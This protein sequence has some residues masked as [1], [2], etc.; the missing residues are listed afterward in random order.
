MSA[1]RDCASPQRSFLLQG[2]PRN[3]R[4][5]LGA[6]TVSLLFSILFRTACTST[7]HRLALD[8]LRHLRGPEAERWAD[9]FLYYHAEFLRGSKA[10]DD[11]FRDFK[12]HVLHVDEN[13]WG[14]ARQEARRWYGRTVD[15]L[16]RREWAEAA[17]AAGVLSHYFSDP[18]MPLHT[19][20]CEE[21]TKV[22]RA[23]EWSISKS[24]GRLQQIIELDLGGY[25]QLEAPPREDWLE[26]LIATGAELAHRHYDAVL[27]HYDLPRGVRDPLTGMDEECCSRIA[28][29]LGH[30]VVGFARVLEKALAE[31]EV[32]PPMVETTLPGFLAILAAPLKLAFQ[33]LYDLGERMTIEAVFD[34]VQRTGKVVK[35]LTPDDREIR[36][37]H[38]EEVLKRPLHQLDQ[39]PT[40]LTGTLYGSGR[41]ERHL[42]NRLLT[43]SPLV[44]PRDSQAW[45][46]A[47]FRSQGSGVRSQESVARRLEPV[48]SGSKRFDVVAPASNPHSTL[49]TPHVPANR[50]SAIRNPQSPKLVFHLSPQSPVVDAPSIGPKIAARLEKAGIVTVGDLLSAEPENLANAMRTK[51]ITADCIRQWQREAALVCRVPELRGTDAQLLVASGIGEPEEL[52]A[53]VPQELLEKI[54]PFATSDAGLRLLHNQ[55][56]PNLADVTRWI[57]RADNSRLLQAA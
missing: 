52:A 49:H 46:E 27:Q 40:K 7:H 36:R 43:G 44:S 1:P 13:L 33:H 15:A 2:A 45:R 41:E 9:V 16:R 10:P 23:L 39:Q 56:P 18:F 42:S 37:L 20:Q 26:R 8:G 29:C 11:Q 28:E 19:G 6:S 57:E 22:H 35:N 21:E 24:Y 47:Q 38:A 34:E 3:L 4:L 50:H 14:G 51:H 12:N 5:R 54:T 25:P 32:E 55:Q 48:A 17:F 30:A 31:A 53:S